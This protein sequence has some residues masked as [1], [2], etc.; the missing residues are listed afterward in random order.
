MSDSIRRVSTIF[1]IDDNQHNQKLKSIN[2]QYKLTQS[3]IKLAGERLKGFGNSTDDLK[4]KQAALEKQITTLR[5]KSNLYTDSIEKATKKAN[6]NKSKLDELGKTKESLN[7]QYNEAVKVYGKESDQAK[8]LKAELDKVNEE[9]TEQERVVTKNVDAVNKYKSEMNKTEAQLAGVQVEL[10][11]T[12]AQ[13][14]KTSNKWLIASEKMNVASKAMKDTGKTM[15]D[16]GGSL[17][18]YVTL[19]I[20]AMGTVA[21]AEAI[22]F[23]SSFAGVQKTVDGTAEQMKKL[24]KG[25]ID[26]SRKI[27]ATTH[28]ISAVAEAAGQ[29]GIQ[30]DNVIGFTKV[31]IDLGESTNMSS[32]QAATSLARLAN[33]TGMSQQDFDKLGSVVVELGKDYCPVAEKLAA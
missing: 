5:E 25:I 28:E 11:K 14:E 12:N 23:E 33:I 32:D 29:L 21:V 9:Y 10:N 4:F 22:K 19:P 7:K 27:P 6:E 2:Q 16:I 3:E 1:T 15:K 13:L 31:I 18:K 20:A 8:T 30:A 17:N 26:M 24:E